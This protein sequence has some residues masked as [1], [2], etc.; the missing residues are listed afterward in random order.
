MVLLTINTFMSNKTKLIYSQEQR[1]AKASYGSLKLNCLREKSE[2]RLALRL[3]DPEL[4]ADPGRSSPAARPTTPGRARDLG[5]TSPGEAGRSSDRA[6]PLLESVIDRKSARPGEY[7][8]PQTG[9]IEKDRER[10]GGTRCRSRGSR[11]TD[12]SNKMQEASSS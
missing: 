6:Q 8:F 5:P 1:E 2:I 11:Q 10:R 4:P 7:P 9:Q 3:R 12:K